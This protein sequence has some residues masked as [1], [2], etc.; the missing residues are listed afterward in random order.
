M[1]KYRIVFMGTPSYAT[2]ILKALLQADDMEVCALFTQPD[3]KAGRGQSLNFPHIKQF[4]ADEGLDIGIFQPESVKNT[5]IHQQISALKPDFIIVAAYGKILPRAVLDI[6]PCI[7]L[8]ASLLPLYRGAS[9][10]QQ[11]ILNDERYSGVTAMSMEEGLDTGDILGFSYCDI[12]ELDSDALF[13]LLSQKAAGLTLK[14]IR[15]YENIL[16][17]KQNDALSSKTAKISKDDG[18]VDFDFGWRELK[19][20]LLA[21]TPWPGLF[22]SSGLKLKSFECEASG[23][24]AKSGQ[25]IKINDESVSVACKDGV[26]KLLKVQA[27]S[28]GEI[29]ASSYVN[30]QRIKV[31]DTFY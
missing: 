6:A 21:L 14:V 25:I 28:K 24:N 27:P 15:S 2:T 7:N 12:K 26:V 11:A 1:K 19:Q 17:I 22:L 3:K 8:H 30:G 9:P 13:E 18:L 29:S 20:K 5:D 31:G 10:I 4:V 23:T 16:H